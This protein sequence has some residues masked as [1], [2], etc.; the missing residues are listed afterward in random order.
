MRRGRP[1]PAVTQPPPPLSAQLNPNRSTVL[2]VNNQLIILNTVII[3][4]NTVTNAIIIFITLKSNLTL[5]THLCHLAEQAYQHPTQY[6]T[7]CSF[8]SINSQS[9]SNLFPCPQVKKKI[10]AICFRP[11]SRLFCWLC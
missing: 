2:F 4:I 6:T 5:I 9:L 11:F 7:H 10:A 3:V 8:S 1:Y